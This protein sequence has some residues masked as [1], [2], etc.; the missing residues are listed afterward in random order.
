MDPIAQNLHFLNQGLDLLGGVDETLYRSA[1]SDG[2]GGAIGA[3]FRHVID[4]YQCFLSGL[5]S[6]RI[7]YDARCRAGD[8]ED[9]P[10]CAIAAMREIAAALGKLQPGDVV[11]PVE[12][13]AD[14]GDAEDPASWNRSSVGRELA[15]LTSHT[16]HHYAL[17]ALLLRRNGHQPDDTFGFAPS[18]LEYL[19]ATAACAR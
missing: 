16:V 11:R 2:R 7:D 10:A 14:A 19:A 4:F 15:F 3:H 8:L 17:I 5:E 18:T 9:D 13:K 6:G 1:D 12:V